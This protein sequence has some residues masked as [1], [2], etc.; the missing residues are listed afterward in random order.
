M[1]LSIRNVDQMMEDTWLLCFLFADAGA[2]IFSERKKKKNL[3]D[4]DAM[5]LL[6]LISSLH[7]ASK[8]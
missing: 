3:F 8:N 2:F 7:I 6:L 1:A 5:S 4:F